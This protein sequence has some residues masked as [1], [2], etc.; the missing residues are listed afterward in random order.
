MKQVLSLS[1]AKVGDPVVCPTI[2]HV[3]I[4]SAFRSGKIKERYVGIIGHVEGFSMNSTGEIVFSVRS[5]FGELEEVH[6]ANVL[7]FT[8][9]T[10]YYKEVDSAR[11]K[12]FHLVCES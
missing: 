1:I 4:D 3:V 12:K 11:A 9:R 5:S 6:A 7:E 8:G 10:A 2:E